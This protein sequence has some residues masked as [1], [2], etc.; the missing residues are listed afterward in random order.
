MSASFG[1]YLFRHDEF[2][3]ANARNTTTRR[4]CTVHSRSPE[5]E[6]RLLLVREPT[7]CDLNLAVLLLLLLLLLGIDF[8]F[9]SR[10]PPVPLS[11]SPLSLCPPPPIAPLPSPSPPRPRVSARADSL[12]PNLMPRVIRPSFQAPFSSLSVISHSALLSLLSLPPSASLPSVP[13]H[14]PPPAWM[15]A[16]NP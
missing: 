14:A 1:S 6:M 16:P 15:P 7:P 12:S 9:P 4:S 2:R 13:L 11:F 8:S 10:I 3:E 5:C